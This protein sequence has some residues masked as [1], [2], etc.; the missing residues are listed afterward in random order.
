MGAVWG[1]VRWR[2]SMHP[3]VLALVINVLGRWS[4]IRPDD[5]VYHS[6]G[7]NQSLGMPCFHAPYNSQYSSFFV[8]SPLWYS[9]I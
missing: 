9:T 2:E 1:M 7:Q 5:V 8:Q 6:I 3:Y 4:L